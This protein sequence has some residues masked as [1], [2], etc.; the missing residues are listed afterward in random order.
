MKTFC[1]R[2]RKEVRIEKVQCRDLAYNTFNSVV[3]DSEKFLKLTT[4]IDV[5]SVPT[6]SFVV[7]NC[8]MIFVKSGTTTAEIR[9]LHAIQISIKPRK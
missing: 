7:W 5:V 2:F 1:H 3:Q 9:A 4:Y 6:S 8:C